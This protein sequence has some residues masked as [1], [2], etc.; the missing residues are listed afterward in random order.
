M[1]Q[2]RDLSALWRVSLVVV[3][4]LLDI[5][6]LLGMRKASTGSFKSTL[7]FFLL[8][9]NIFIIE[10]TTETASIYTAARGFIVVGGLDVCREN[11]FRA[12]AQGRS[13]GGA[14]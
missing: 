9:V 12:V 7:I 6:F 2:P 4:I 5:P 10:L 13:S 11:L 14:G 8:V 1:E 3:Q